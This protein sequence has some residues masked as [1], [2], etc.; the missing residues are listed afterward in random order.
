MRGDDITIATKQSM[1]NGEIKEGIL[2]Y[3]ETNE[4]G[5]TTFQNLWE[6]AKAVLKVHSNLHWPQEIRKISNNM[7]VHFNELEK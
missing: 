3:L 7:N 1:V 4:N 6:T 5:D 2:K